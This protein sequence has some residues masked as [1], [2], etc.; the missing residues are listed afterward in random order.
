[1]F[2]PL[3]VP[4]RSPTEPAICALDV[5]R[6][7]RSV[8]RSLDCEELLVVDTGPACHDR[9]RGR[10]RRPRRRTDRACPHP[11]ELLGLT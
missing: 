1:V 4:S 3:A 6:G 8:M 2:R 5:T 10:R 7:A 11:P 9:R